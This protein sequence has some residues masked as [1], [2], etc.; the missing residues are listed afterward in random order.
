MSQHRILTREIVHE[1]KT[2]RPSDGRTVRFAVE[3]I[4]QGTTK[5]DKRVRLVLK[6]AR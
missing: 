4:F 5:S 3:E 2:A 1:G 6:A